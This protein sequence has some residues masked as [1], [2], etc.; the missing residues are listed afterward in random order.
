M[1][2]TGI[3]IKECSIHL[4]QTRDGLLLYFTYSSVTCEV[5][6]VSCSKK[7]AISLEKPI[8]FLNSPQN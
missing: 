2:G 4:L 7:A 5:A 8:Q 1:Y 3:K 6:D